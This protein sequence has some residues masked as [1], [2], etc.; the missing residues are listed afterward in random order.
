MRPRQEVRNVEAKGH[1]GSNEDVETGNNNGREENGKGQ[2]EERKGRQGEDQHSNKAHTE[3][4]DIAG[5]KSSGE[6]RTGGPNGWHDMG[7]D[8]DET[9]GAETTNIVGG[10]GVCT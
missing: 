9:S 5:M 1:V 10:L 4:C 8:S 2:S 6:Q 7:A 3:R